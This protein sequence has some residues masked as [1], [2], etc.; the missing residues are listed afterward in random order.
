M[1][2]EEILNTLDKPRI[3]EYI[4]AQ[5][6]TRWGIKKVNY[7]QGFI[8]SVDYSF[9][10]FPMMKLEILASVANKEYFITSGFNFNY[11]PEHDE[12]TSDLKSK[13]EPGKNEFAYLFINYTPQPFESK[14][15]LFESLSRNER[16]S[17]ES[18]VYLRNSTTPDT[19]TKIKKEDEWK[20]YLLEI[21]I[22]TISMESPEIRKIIMDKIRREVDEITKMQNIQYF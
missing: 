3:I 6:V 7:D 18:N 11:H 19:I 17:K 9:V 21:F 13:L 8:R 20:E 5:I 10:D 16:F 2:E 1:K 4:A 15:N 12:F 22:S 14:G